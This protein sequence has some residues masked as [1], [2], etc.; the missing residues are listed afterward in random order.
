VSRVAGLR[1]RWGAAGSAALGTWGVSRLGVVVLVWISGWIFIADHSMPGSWLD[2]WSHWDAGIFLGIAQKGYFGAGTDP[3]HVAF[4]PGFPWAVDAVH[5]VARNWVASGLVVSAVAGAFACVALGRLAAD[6]VDENA[7]EA[8]KNAVLFFVTAPAAIFLA[9][10]YSESLFAAFAFSAWYAARRNRWLTASLCGAA[11]SIVRVNGLFLAAA[12]ALEFL[13]AG[14]DRRRWRQLPLLV[15]PALPV[16]GYVT[17]LH[18]RTGDWLAWQHAQAAGWFRTFS[19]PMSAW[20]QTWA[21]AF[22]TTQNGH[23]AWVFQL[24]LLAVLVGIG[25]TVWLLAMRRWPEALYVSLSLFALSTTTWFM[26]VPRA[27]LLWWPLWT[28]LGAWAAQRPIVRT[29]YL[30]CVAPVM[31]GVALLFLSGQWAG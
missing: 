12:I 23:T 8:A 15:V 13:L 3:T 22:G 18:A 9:A 4:F 7:S 27:M 17:Y 2:R 10:G 24:E 1:A 6:Q 19:D 14:R 29:L 31:V 28:G 21:A 25:L 26:S 30:W 20:D 11:A 16:V 5:V